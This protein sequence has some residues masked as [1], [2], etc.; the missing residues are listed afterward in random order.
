MTEKEFQKD[1]S[2]LYQFLSAF[3]EQCY[4]LKSDS[5]IIDNNFS[6]KYD[7]I[8]ISEA[9]E[10]LTLDPFPAE[11]IERI[12]NIWHEDQ[13]TKAWFASIVTKLEAK[14]AEAERNL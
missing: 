3:V 5:E 13:S 2:E 4:V 11:A 8:A 6:L 12:T 9:H 10:V 14:I 7:K 1:F